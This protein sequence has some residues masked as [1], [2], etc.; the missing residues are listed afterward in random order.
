[1]TPILYNITIN[2]ILFI[3]IKYILKLKIMDKI[4]YMW[5]FDLV[6]N[7]AISNLES[8]IYYMSNSKLGVPIY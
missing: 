6:Q 8:L 7:E 2:I 1:M 4:D 5:Q 3:I